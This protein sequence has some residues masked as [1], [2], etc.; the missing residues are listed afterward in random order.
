MAAACRLISG[1]RREVDRNYAHLSYYAAYSGNFAPTFRDTL[2]AA[3]REIDAACCLISGFRREV[4]RNC[5]HLSYYAGYS[6]NFLP[7]FRDNLSVPSS[8]AKNQLSTTDFRNRKTGPIGYPETSARNYH[9]TLR[10]SPEERSSQIRSTLVTILV[11][12][13]RLYH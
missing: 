3:C 8:R 13:T 7:T 4:D 11:C 5:A 10:N 12:L 1:F 6:S 9:S 2:S